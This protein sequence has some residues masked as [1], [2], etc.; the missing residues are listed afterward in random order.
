MLIIGWL[1]DSF[2]GTSPWCL[3]GGIVLGAVIG[4]YQF[5]KLTSQILKN[6]K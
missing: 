5:F 6:D 2:L 1:L 3:I 4:F